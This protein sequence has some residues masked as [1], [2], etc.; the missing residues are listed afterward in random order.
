MEK[1]K[2]VQA[3]YEAVAEAL[4]IQVTSADSDSFDFASGAASQ[5]ID[6]YERDNGV[7][8]N[9]EQRSHVF[10]IISAAIADAYSEHTLLRRF[11]PDVVEDEVDVVN[12]WGR[13]GPQLPD[14]YW[15]DGAPG[16]AGAAIEMHRD[17]HMFAFTLFPP[18][19][20]VFVE[21]MYGALSVADEGY[22]LDDF[23][24]KSVASVFRAIAECEGR[25]APKRAFQRALE[26]YDPNW[27]S[28]SRERE[29]VKQI[30]AASGRRRRR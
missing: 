18:F 20:T 13:R 19:R 26:G 16:P 23:D 6:E 5:W 10:D 25:G 30:E 17:G 27:W 4:G 29:L 11:L 28:Q 1:T 24:L 7:K 12:A 14:S 9:D 3:D 8:L 21:A 22:D 2:H 15:Q